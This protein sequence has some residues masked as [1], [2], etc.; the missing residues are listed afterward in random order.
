ME[1]KFPIERIYAVIDEYLWKNHINNKNYIYIPNNVP[2]HSK[3]KVLINIINISNNSNL[4]INSYYNL[5]R[6][7]IKGL[8]DASDFIDDVQLN[9]YTI[10]NETFDETLQ[11][12]VKRRYFNTRYIIPVS[13]IKTAARRE[14]KEETG[15]IIIFDNAVPNDID[16]GNVQILDTTNVVISKGTYRI[17]ET[18]I[19]ISLLDNEYEKLKQYFLLKDYL[20]GVHQNLDTN[21][22]SDIY[23]KKYLKYKQK[24]LQLQKS[25]NSLNSF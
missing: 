19:H 25:L 8:I 12:T 11:E 17:N 13:V 6:T 20:D 1:D 7:P 4:S 14:F 18:N 2:D 22:V 10:L 24:Y 16:E 15:L 5:S 9:Q 21:E 3:Y 23:M